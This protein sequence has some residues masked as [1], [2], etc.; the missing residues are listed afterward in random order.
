MLNLHSQFLVTALQKN[1]KTNRL[2]KMD[3]HF[4]TTFLNS[5][6]HES[7]AKTPYLYQMIIEGCDV[8]AEQNARR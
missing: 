4:Q 8:T 6:N 2:N 5:I 3:D 1:A 7:L